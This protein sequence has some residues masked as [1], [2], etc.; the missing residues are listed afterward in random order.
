MASAP[1]QHLASAANDA[2]CCNQPQDY[3]APRTNAAQ[4]T[5]LLAFPA[6]RT[7]D[8]GMPQTRPSLHSIPPHPS[9]KKPKPTTATPCPP[10]GTPP[11]SHHRPAPRIPNGTNRTNAPLAPSFYQH[12][13]EVSPSPLPSLPRS[14]QTYLQP[15]GEL[16]DQPTSVNAT[17]PS[18]RMFR[19][20]VPPWTYPLQADVALPLQPSSTSAPHT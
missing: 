18:L 14:A 10:P 16:A 12:P 5:A 3:A 19:A 7:R 17:P 8:A 11:W 9:P 20:R 4:H 2:A 13:L 6:R 15:L 1:E